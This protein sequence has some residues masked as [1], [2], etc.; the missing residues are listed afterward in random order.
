VSRVRLLPLG[1]GILGAA[2]LVAAGTVWRVEVRHS[3]P[4]GFSKTID[5]DRLIAVRGGYVTPNY[6]DFNRLDLDLRAYVPGATYDLT[7]HI[8]PN[9]P[10]A[11]DVRT[12]RLD[13]PA[14]RI[15]DQKGTF[16]D[17]FLTVRFPEIDNSAGQTY[18]VWVEPGI[19]NRDEVVALWSIKSYSRVPARQVVWAFVNEAP[20]GAGREVVRLALILLLGGLVFST[21]WFLSRIVAAAFP[22]PGDLIEGLM[23]WHRR[24]TDGIQ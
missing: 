24:E 5:F 4:Y 12:I 8:R 13:L 19:R 9:V 20:G 16:E 1:V 17:P 18:Y 14:S 7:I 2:L 22:V 3:A 15:S 11:A 6:D 21:G 23:R 10:G